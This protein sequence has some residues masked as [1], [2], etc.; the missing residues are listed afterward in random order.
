MTTLKSLPTSAPSGVPATLS[1]TEISVVIPCLNEARSIGICVEKAL[2]AFREIGIQGEVVVADNGSTDGSI[3]SRRSLV[4]ELSMCRPA[5]TAMPCARESTKQGRVYHHGRRR[6]QLRFLA[7][8]R[9]CRQMAGRRG[10]RHGQ[11]LRGRDQAR[12]HAMASQI[13]GQSRRSQPFSIHSSAQVSAMRTAACGDL[14]RDCMNRSS[15]EL[16]EWNSRWS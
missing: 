3:E 15:R 10:T 13:L 8:P 12:R 16:R 2:A 1:A 6:R 5:V 11:S 9:L 7:G 14:P 4:R